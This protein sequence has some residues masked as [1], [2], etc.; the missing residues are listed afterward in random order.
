MKSGRKIW[1]L[2]AAV[3]VIIVVVVLV[4]LLTSSSGPSGTPTPTPTYTAPPGPTATRTVGPTQTDTCNIYFNTSSFTI[5]KGETVAL[6]VVIDNVDYLASG[7][8]DVLYDKN[9]LNV[10]A[11]PPDGTVNDTYDRTAYGNPATGC[12]PQ[13]VAAVSANGIDIGYGNSTA[14]SGCLRIFW[15]NDWVQNTTG[16]CTAGDGTGQTGEGWLTVVTFKGVGT[17]TSDI[18]FGGGPG[19]GK[20][21]V[22]QILDYVDY[23]DYSYTGIEHL[24]WGPSVQVTVQ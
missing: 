8:F 2:A 15:T 21:Q 7:Q 10:A 22:N 19:G 12:G 4:V 13:S 24:V 6:M 5:G 18:A 16:D 1:L 23:Q 17:G 20:L 9:I 11:D 3:A 14:N